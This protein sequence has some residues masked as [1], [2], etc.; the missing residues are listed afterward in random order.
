MKRI[1]L[2][3]GHNTT[4]L[5][6]GCQDGVDAVMS[7][8]AKDLSLPPMTVVGVY[9]TSEPLVRTSDEE[10]RAMAIVKASMRY[11]PR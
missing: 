2:T 5:Q 10:E 9:E 6:M 4:R 3:D 11:F 8:I 7:A 1:I